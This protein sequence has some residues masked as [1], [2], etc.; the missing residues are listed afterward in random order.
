[1]IPLSK[2]FVSL[3]LALSFSSLP[4]ARCTNAAGLKFLSDNALKEGVVVMPSGLQYSIVIEG[5]GLES[6]FPNTSCLVH[7]MGTLI[8]GTEFDSSYKRGKVR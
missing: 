6:P 3:L 8:D 5:P 7:Y 2:M 4:P 1:M